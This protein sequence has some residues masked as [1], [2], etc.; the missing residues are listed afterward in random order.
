MNLAI[1]NLSKREF[2]YLKRIYL[3]VGMEESH[4]NFTENDLGYK[5][6]KELIEKGFIKWLGSTPTKIDFKLTSNTEDLIDSI[7]QDKIS[8]RNVKEIKSEKYLEDILS[9]DLSVVEEGM[10]FIER[11]YRV[12]DGFI[13]IL[14]RGKDG[15]L[16]IIELKVVDNDKDLVFQSS[17]YPTQFDEEVRMITIAPGYNEKIYKAL[18]NIGSVELL[19]YKL[20]NGLKI[21]K[22]TMEFAIKNSMMEEDWY[23]A[24]GRAFRALDDDKLSLKHSAWTDS[25][26]GSY[27][28]KNKQEAKDV[29][30]YLIINNRKYSKNNLRLV[31]T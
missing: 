23:Y 10:Q 25:I 22:Y 1:S 13:D 8:Y 24:Q 18:R 6:L 9:Q 14:A 21:E 19:K 29:I 20:D 28:F 2:E 3:D 15:K 30:Q 5:I 27:K 12:D 17:Y 26:I 31:T 4:I 7:N 11:Q 16:T